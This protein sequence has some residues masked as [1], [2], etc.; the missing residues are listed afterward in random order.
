MK[1]LQ[2][3][4]KRKSKVMERTPVMTRDQY[5]ALDLDSRL[6]LIQA[7]IP[8][9]LMLVSEE[10]QLEVQQIAG[11]RYQRKIGHNKI[12]RHGSNPGSVKLA[13]QRVP[14]DVPRIRRIKRY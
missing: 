11:S 10:L 8:L 6:A 13:V 12:Y 7:L 3:A 2:K 14:I 9:G 4:R 1:V 5:A